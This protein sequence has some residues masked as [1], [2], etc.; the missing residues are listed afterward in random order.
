VKIFVLSVA[1]ILLTA[2]TLNIETADKKQC[3]RSEDDNQIC[4]KFVSAIKCGDSEAVSKILKQHPNYAQ[5]KD[6]HGNTA[7]HSVSVLCTKKIPGLKPKAGARMVQALV[8]AK[9]DVNA[10]NDRAFTPLLMH[11]LP[12]PCPNDHNLCHCRVSPLGVSTLQALIKN[13]AKFDGGLGEHF[14]FL[15]TQ[16]FMLETFPDTP[17]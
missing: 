8:E 17:E 14:A 7:L 6:K 2:C 16:S 12:H 11:F 5:S 4:Q 3:I 1:G 10:R 9:A 15:E 13:G